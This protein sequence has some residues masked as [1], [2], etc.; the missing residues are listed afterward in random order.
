MHINALIFPAN[1]QFKLMVFKEFSNHR[2]IGKKF[3]NLILLFASAP[4]Y[5]LGLIVVN[6]LKST[7]FGLSAISGIN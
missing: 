2:P 6:S 7:K 1:K 4:Y 3:S 5:S